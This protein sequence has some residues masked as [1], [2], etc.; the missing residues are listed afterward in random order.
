MEGMW[1]RQCHCLSE[2]LRAEKR[3]RG[4]SST[5]GGSRTARSRNTGPV[6][7]TLDFSRKSEA[8]RRRARAKEV[9]L[10][11]GQNA[12]ITARGRAGPK[13]YALSLASTGAATYS[14]SHAGWGMSSKWVGFTPRVLIE[15]NAP[16]I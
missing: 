16:S 14:D 1:T 3:S 8:G 15:R 9:L 12:G 7:M 13:T 4:T 10:R 5:S 2:Y 6:A 11:G